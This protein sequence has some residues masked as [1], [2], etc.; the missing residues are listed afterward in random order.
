MV[1]K[2]TGSP[3]SFFSSVLFLVREAE[4]TIGKT[5][6]KHQ[7]G[8][9]IQ[10]KQE[11]RIVDDMKEVTQGDSSTKRQLHTSLLMMLKR[12]SVQRDFYKNDS[13]PILFIHHNRCC[14]LPLATTNCPPPTTTVTVNHYNRSSPLLAT[15]HN[16]HHQL[17]LPQQPSITTDNQHHQTAAQLIVANA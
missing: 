8:N 3:F 10:K 16:H 1:F 6:N 14:R 9:H 17:P 15:I 4:N 5:E 11:L 12:I 7:L 13:S 2:Q